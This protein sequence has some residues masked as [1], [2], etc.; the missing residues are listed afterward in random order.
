MNTIYAEAIYDD[1]LRCKENSDL[2]FNIEIVKTANDYGRLFNKMAG[3]RLKYPTI[4]IDCRFFEYIK[5]KI[6]DMYE[7]VNT[8]GNKKSCEY[9][10]IN[11][12]PMELYPLI[13]IM[14][15]DAAELAYLEDFVK[16]LYTDSKKISVQYPLNNDE[17]IEFYV[18]RNPKEG[19]K[20]SQ[21]DIGDE[22]VY[23]SCIRLETSI[24]VSFT[25]RYHPA[26]LELDQYSRLDIVE[27]LAALEEI[28]RRLI[29]NNNSKYAEKILLVDKAWTNLDSIAHYG[30]DQITYS[31]LY[32]AM[33]NGVPEKWCDVD[34]AKALL[35][36]KIRK[37]NEAKRKSKERADEVRKKTSKKQ[38][39]CVNIFTDAFINDMKK[40]VGLRKP[41]TIYGG[42]NASDWHIKKEEGALECPNILILGN[43]NFVY[44]EE[45]YENIDKNGNLV[46]H[47]YSLDAMPMT[48]GVQLQIMAKSFEEVKEIKNEIIQTYE[49]GSVLYIDYP[50][51]KDE[52]IKQD[53][54]CDMNEAAQNQIIQENF[55]GE[56]VYKTNIIFKR[57]KS[58]YFPTKYTIGDIKD[59]PAFQFRL[60]QQ[61]QFWVYC[62]YKI[63]DEAIPQLEGV[64]KELFVEKKKRN[65]SEKL[66]DTL[67]EPA[68]YKEL[69]RRVKR[70]ERIDK[71]L[72]ESC[73]F[74]VIP[75]CPDLYEKMMSNYPYEKIKD[76]LTKKAEE[77]NGKWNRICNDLAL[78]ECPT[79]FTQL[80]MS[81]DKN[82]VNEQINSGLTFYINTMAQ[83]PFCTISDAVKAYDDYLEMMRQEEERKRQEEYEAYRERH[84]NYN[85][86]DD[87]SGS[88]IGGLFGSA[89][90]TSLGTRGL[91]KELKKQTSIMEQQQKQ[92]EKAERERRHREALESQRR[93]RA[94][95]EENERRR[96]KGQPELPLPPRSWD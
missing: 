59:N 58:V 47:P 90:G 15:T 6:V 65:F 26:Q 22:H 44:G 55:N 96:R 88:I 86:D 73:F 83:N 75:V 52:Y 30:D 91:R 40:K 57:S 11:T 10:Y 95:K 35:K 3:N 38:D 81:G 17:Y 45:N 60:V 94:V 70:K 77:Y 21:D 46:N 27:R 2:N 64:Y 28:R 79:M 93:W 76:K 92:A 20:R 68:E 42:S 87:S 71:A 82:I 4:Y 29:Q 18:S 9:N 72:F 8:D 1:F 63:S 13:N 16:M 39:E 51:S 33:L 48:F 74:K 41:I 7:V 84:N 54:E 69:R 31:M 62:D 43:L 49:N 37:E 78:G 36:E 23:L 53:I 66:V 56:T 34:E 80:G 32:D 50:Y 19:F 5:N 89:M 25:E 85:E 24:C 14:T 12:L 67:F 61:A